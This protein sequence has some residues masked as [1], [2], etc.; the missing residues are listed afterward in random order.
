[1]LLYFS[2]V[3]LNISEYDCMRYSEGLALQIANDIVLDSAKDFSNEL[4]R[5]SVERVRSLANAAS[6]NGETH[7]EYSVPITY[8]NRY[9]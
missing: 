4:D 5:V 3:G 7:L 2:E 6:Y 8:V 9:T 1:M